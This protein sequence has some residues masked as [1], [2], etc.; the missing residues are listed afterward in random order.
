LYLTRKVGLSSEE[1]L[2]GQPPG[3][4]TKLYDHT[5]ERLTVNEISRWGL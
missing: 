2:G 3:A 5:K 1:A 4:R